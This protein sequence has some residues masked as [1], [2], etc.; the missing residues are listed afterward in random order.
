MQRGYT[1]VVARL[2]KAGA[3][4]TATVKSAVERAIALLQKSGPQFVKVS[5]C[6]SCHNQSLPQ[7]A[8]NEARSRG[9]AVDEQISQQQVKAVIAMFKPMHDLMM[10]GTDKFPDPPISVSYSLLGLAAEH[11]H[12]DSTTDAMAHLIATKQLPDGSFRAIAARPPLESSDIS[13]TAL[14]LR[15]LQ[16]YGEQDAETRVASAREWLRSAQPSTSE[17]R[18]MRLMGMA[19]GNAP[20]E[21]IANAA[22]EVIARQNSDGGWSQLPGLESDAYATGQ[23]MAALKWAGQVEITDPVWR[24]GVTFLLRTQLADGSWLVHSRTFPFQ[25]YKESGFPHGKDQWI[26]AAGTSWAAAVLSMSM[27]ERPVVSASLASGN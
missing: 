18:A 26:S 3:S 25:P 1:P 21:D 17:D 7:M 16:I 23:A 5:G 12:R 9:L 4:D 15:A 6:T 22:E 13:A 2:E 10:E 27:P 8:I 14:S 20:S 11:Y 24:R 19:W